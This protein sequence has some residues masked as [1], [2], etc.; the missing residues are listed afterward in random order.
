MK[1]MYLSV[2]LAFMSAMAMAQ[3]G[4]KSVDVNIN[5]HKGGDAWYSNPIV[6][7]VGAAVF[8]LLLV[9]LSRGRSRD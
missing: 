7:I 9:A 8:I 5:T 6:W 4:T 1:K 3:D 2:A